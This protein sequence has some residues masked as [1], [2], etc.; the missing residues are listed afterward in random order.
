V[1]FEVTARMPG[2]YPGMDKF[3]AMLRR[4]APSTEP[5]EAALAGWTSAELFVTGL[6]AIGPN[7]TRTRL[8]AALNRIADF[9]AG[10]IQPPIDWRTGHQVSQGQLGCS[11]YVQVQRGAYVPVYGTP[12]SV[13]SCFAL[14]GPAGPPLTPVVPLPAGVPPGTATTGTG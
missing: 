12:P 5:S 2:T 6:R 13:F 4:Y 7:V 9:T 8:V 10:G 11:A 3:L 14:P 1:P